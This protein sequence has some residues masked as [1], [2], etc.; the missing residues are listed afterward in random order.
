MNYSDITDALSRADIDVALPGARQ[1]V[2]VSPYAVVQK[3]GTYRYASSPRLGY[4]VITVH[5][6]VPL[7]CYGQLDILI[8]RVKAA[9]RTLSPDLRPSG[10]EGI[11]LINDHFRAHESSVQYMLQKRLS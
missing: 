10:S 9:L 2:C 1:G 4:T 6:Y 11:H 8:G 7:G 5:C 3:T